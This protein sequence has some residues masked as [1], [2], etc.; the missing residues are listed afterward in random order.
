MNSTGSVILLGG[1]C[2]M[3][4]VGVF[5]FNS[6]NTE[7]NTT[8]TDPVVKEQQAATN[9]ITVPLYTLLCYGILAVACYTVIN[10]Y[11]QM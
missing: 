6:L 9:S 3:L 11:K 5:A 7:A 2:I 8:I 4:V 10:S 1:I